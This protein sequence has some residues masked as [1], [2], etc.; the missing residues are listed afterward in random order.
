[1]RNVEYTDHP[2]L[3]A[4]FV[5]AGV[6]ASDAW[7]TDDLGAIFCVDI[8]KWNLLWLA[9]A[10]PEPRDFWLQLPI[11]RDIHLFLDKQTRHYL[12]GGPYQFMHYWR[13]I[14]DGRLNIARNFPP[15]YF[16]I[17]MAKAR[18][19]E[20]RLHPGKL[21]NVIDVD[22]R[23]GL[24]LGHKAHRPRFRCDTFH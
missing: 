15:H 3:N 18:L 17:M 1:M 20:E 10:D 21:G 4:P 23:H 12:Q 16:E 14:D 24:I 8:P 6:Q 22:F 9:C 11:A 13:Q 2:L 7:L 5:Y 19:A